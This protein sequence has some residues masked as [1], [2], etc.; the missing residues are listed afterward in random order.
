MSEGSIVTHLLDAA[1]AYDRTGALEEA[2]AGYEAAVVEAE[3]LEDS[4]VQAE[5]LRRLAVTRHRLREVPAAHSLAERSCEVAV[6]AG[7]AVLLAEGLNTLGGFHLVE[8][9]F[10]QAQEKFRQAL[11]HSAGGSQLRGRIE[12]NLGTV[13]SSQGD[14]TEAMVHYQQSLA[15]FLAAGDEH[16][17]AIAYHNLGVVS[18]ERRSWVDAEAHF[19]LALSAADRTG[20]THLKGLVLLN[21]SEAL[22]ALGR[23]PEARRAAEAAT[24]IFDELRASAELGDAYRVL[25]VILRDSG[26]LKLA[27]ARLR[28][29]AELSATAGSAAGEAE[30]L[31]DLAV[32]LALAG[33]VEE[34]VKLL[35]VSTRVL[36]RLKP[37]LQPEA[38]MEGNYP[39]AVR[40]WGELMRVRDL[41][42]LEH[43]ERVG[44]AAAAVAC[45]LG[46]DAPAQARVRMAAFL[47]G[48]SPDLIEA[49]ELPWG[50]VESRRACG[51]CLGHPDRQDS[52]ADLPPEAQ[53]IGIVDRYDYF[54][55]PLP[56]GRGLSDRDALSQ[57][58]THR[59]SWDAGIYAAFLRSRAA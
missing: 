47:H 3:R 57:M 23:L 46:W 13:R 45:E 7:S 14:H 44:A 5:A 38:V 41:S 6:K 42:E 15:A 27:Q 59:S 24:G 32:T 37:S 16:S 29:A 4:S 2:A 20:D 56:A 43:A 51:D 10:K 34:A 39:A 12:Q 55:M 25:G 28:L 17:C 31:R 9:Q 40:A 11:Q 53:M 21:R 58:E 26:S 35:V 19:R 30:A 49:A 8:E 54:R 50:L 33:E 1:R 48:V 36:G 18:Q 52:A 22:V